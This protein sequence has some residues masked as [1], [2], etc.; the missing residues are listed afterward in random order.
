MNV[1]LC[2]HPGCRENAVLVASCPNL[3]AP[4][5]VCADHIGW[6]VQLQFTAPELRAAVVEFKLVPQALAS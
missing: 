6:I 2:D 1:R 3:D 5:D 4:H